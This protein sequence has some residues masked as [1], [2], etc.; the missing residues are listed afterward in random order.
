MQEQQ[1]RSRKLCKSDK[2]IASNQLSTQKAGS[3]S[4]LKSFSL[5]THT[6]DFCFGKK[7]CT[8]NIIVTIFHYTYKTNLKAVNLKTLRLSQIL[9]NYYKILIKLLNYFW[10][11]SIFS[12]QFLQVM[13]NLQELLQCASRI[14]MA[15]FQRRLHCIFLENVRPCLGQVPASAT[16]LERYPLSDFPPPFSFWRAPACIAA[17]ICGQMGIIYKCPQVLFHCFGHIS[18]QPDCW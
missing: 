9:L 17:Y 1:Q 2:C 7:K 14:K 16:A 8:K 11:F 5:A 6:F 13:E 3:F 18:M 10:I 4:C 15:A 12:I